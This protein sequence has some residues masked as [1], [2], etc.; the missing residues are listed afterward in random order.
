M[1]TLSEQ[2]QRIPHLLVLASC[3]GGALL[4]G[5]CASS[6]GSS[7]EAKQAQPAGNSPALPPGV[8]L[9]QDKDIN[10]VWLAEGFDFRGYD[11]L[12]IA[13]TRFSAAERANEAQMRE[14]AIRVLRETLTEYLSQ[15]KVFGAVTTRAEDIKPDTKTLRLENTIIEYQKGGGG[16]RY[17]AGMFG[18]GQPVIKVRGL[19]TAGDKLMC[20]YEMRRSGES[21]GARMN[22]V[23]QSDEEIQRNDIRDL[24]SDFSDFVKR[25]AKAQ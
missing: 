5:G 22:G 17:W 1:K 20:V 4:L 19:L 14:M 18:G 23:F 10:G 16:A 21:A 8:T 24:A 15:T 7:S 6:S 9:H 13:E 25:T 11:L 2:G 12:Y 3:L